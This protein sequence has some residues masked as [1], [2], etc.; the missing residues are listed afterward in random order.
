MYLTSHA[1][2]ILIHQQRIK[3]ADFG[4]SRKIAESSSNSGILGVV[5]YV[6]PKSFNNQNNKSLNYKLSKKSDVYS[7]GVLIWQISSGYEPF[8][9]KAGVGL[10]MTIYN[11]L[12]EEIIEGTSAKYSELYAGNE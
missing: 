5:P 1:G 12:R 6:D 9:D 7:V 3:L 2:N 8:K 11:G 4:L 10:I